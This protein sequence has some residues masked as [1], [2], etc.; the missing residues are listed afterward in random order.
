[1]KTPNERV[2]P[3][4]HL[5]HEE[6]V[7]LDAL[8]KYNPVAKNP[9]IFNVIP[10]FLGGTLY[11]FELGE[12]TADG[13]EEE[14]CVIVKNGHP[15]VY[16]D[17]EQVLRG[18]VESRSLISEIFSPNVILAVI[19]AIILLGSIAIYA[20][21]G[22]VEEPFRGALTAVLGFWFGKSLPTK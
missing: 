3:A 10:N 17:Y 4:A 9:H 8:V 1:M 5:K 7:A 16:Y 15:K 22:T 13:R 11:L 19:S 18:V 21:K 14:W 20:M 6:Q 12:E 2:P